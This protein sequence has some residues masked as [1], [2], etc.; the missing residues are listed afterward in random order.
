MDFFSQFQAQLQQFNARLVEQ[1]R[2]LTASLPQGES[3]VWVNGQKVSSL[4]NLPVAT[5]T[6]ITNGNVVTR[7]VSLADSIAS[8]HSQG[9]VTVIQFGNGSNAP[10]SLLARGQ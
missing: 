8:F 3:G 6:T 4:P 2:S 10:E 7:T 5:E 1:A 9:G